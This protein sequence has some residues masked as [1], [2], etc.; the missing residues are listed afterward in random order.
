MNKL[1]LIGISLVV[2]V[3][4]VVLLSGNKQKQPEQQVTAPTSTVSEP[5][6]SL[7]PAENLEGTMVVITATGFEPKTVTVKAGTKVTWT[8]NSGEVSNVSSAV[9]PT[10]LVYPPLN[11]GNIEAGVS[12]S[13]VF[14]KVGSYKYHNH[15]DASQTGTVVVE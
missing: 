1:L 7:S 2:V 4:A 12:V 8:N 13:L 15:L 3:V 11:L 5:T 14:D 6:V 9:H 10:H